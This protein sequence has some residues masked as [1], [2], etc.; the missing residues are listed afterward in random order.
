MI[1]RLYQGHDHGSQPLTLPGLT[2]PAP[3]RC[4]LVI[5]SASKSPRTAHY[6][7]RKKPRI[8]RSSE[9]TTIAIALFT[10]FRVL[11]WPPIV[12][13]NLFP[14]HEVGGSVAELPQPEAQPCLR[15]FLCKYYRRKSCC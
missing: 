13:D 9:T 11:I 2:N 5:G 6:R 4:L 14:M 10:L 7:R 12:P 1:H 8:I 3:G 15:S